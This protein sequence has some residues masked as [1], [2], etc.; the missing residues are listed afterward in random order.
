[1]RSEPGFIVLIA[2]ASVTFAWAGSAAAD[3]CRAVPDRGPLPPMLK[4]GAQ[5]AGPVVYVGDG[6][7][8][9]VGVSSTPEGWVEVRLADFYAPE[10]SE[11]SGRMAKDKLAKLALGRGVTCR[12]SGRS[13]DRVVATCILN[14]SSL[15]DAL[16]AAGAPEGGRGL[17]WPVRAPR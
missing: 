13:Y 1:M 7:S 14:G 17:S 16:R 12:V 4:A 11:P 3:P 2:A 8:L 5:F 15:G 9:C 6:D 10:L